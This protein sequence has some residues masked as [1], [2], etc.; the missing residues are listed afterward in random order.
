MEKVKTRKKDL[1]LI[2][3]AEEKLLLL[4]Q[5]NIKDTKETNDLCCFIAIKRMYLKSK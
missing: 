1:M 5:K 2:K 4:K 3:M